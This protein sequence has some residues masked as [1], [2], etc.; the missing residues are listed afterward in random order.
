MA[1]RPLVVI[2]DVFSDR[3]FSDVD[4]NNITLYDYG[5]LDEYTYFDHVINPKTGNYSGIGNY[6]YRMPTRL[7][8]VG[9]FYEF[10]Y[11][12]E[13][14]LGED[15]SSQQDFDWDYLSTS[16]FTDDFYNTAY[17]DKFEYFARTDE[18]SHDAV[19][20]GDW[21]LNSFINQLDGTDTHILCVDVDTLNNLIDGTFEHGDNEAH[22][23]KLFAPVQ[24]NMQG[25]AGKIP[26][27][28]NIV[29]NFY[30]ENDARFTGD[31]NDDTYLP[32]LVSASIAGAEASVSSP[33]SQ[34][35]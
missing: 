14:W 15:L 23:S 27:L 10:S 20:H 28:I 18:E 9:G 1:I 7:D 16:E 11:D 25:A 17:A 21:T 13:T 3:I 32:V 22:W 6:D 12:T 8:T 26:A 35:H 19:C 30:F 4:Y 34:Y 29:E 5:F 2:V 33:I 24:T 31:V